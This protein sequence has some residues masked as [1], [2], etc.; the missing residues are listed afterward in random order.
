MDQFN[1]ETM[2]VLV[3]G[4]TGLLG[5]W[6]AETYSSKGFKVYATYNEKNPPGLEAA[7]IKL[8]LE[9][10]ESI[11]SVVREV[12]PDIIVHS[13]AYTD[14]DGCEVNKEKAYRVNYLGTEALARAGR[15]TDYFIYVSTDYVFNGEKGLYREEDTPAPVNY[16]G[17]SKLLGEVAVRAI[18]PK[19]SVIVRVSGLYGY[20]PTGK[21]NFGV[22]VLERLLRGE[23]VEA[24]IDQW[25]SPTYTRFLSEILAKLVDTK[26]TGVLHIAGERLSRYEFARLFAEVLGVGENLVKPRPLESVNLPARRPRDSSLN[27]A[28]AR[29]LGLSLPPVPD[30]LKDMVSTYRR[31]IEG[32]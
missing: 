8:N 11:I 6:I 16:Y 17:L 26:P 32:L 31:F 1:G 23:N 15:E 20:S 21:K 28:K 5:Y 22:I 24:F 3:T 7:W 14:V 27:T 4:G 2:R 9:D 10:P 18:L 30:C 29:V 19:N 13:A 12:R 25:L